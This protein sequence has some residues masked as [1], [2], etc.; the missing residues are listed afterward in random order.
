MALPAS[1]LLNQEGVEA[2]IAGMK[3]KTRTEKW[4]KYRSKIK[5]LPVEA[6]EEKKEN[7]ISF[8]KV[9]RHR[10]EESLSPSY[11]PR[12]QTTPYRAFQARKRRNLLIKVGAL[13]LT[14]L[15]FVLAYFFLVK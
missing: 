15:V 6:F 8:S 5:S 2:R 10:L 14:V 13:F 4:K 12:L 9:D 3:A 11:E 1:F 7:A